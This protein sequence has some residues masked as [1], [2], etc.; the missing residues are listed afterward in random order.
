MNDSLAYTTGVAKGMLRIDP[1]FPID[2]DNS[3]AKTNVFSPYPTSASDPTWWRPLENPRV[4]GISSEYFRDDFIGM[5]SGEEADEMEK[6]IAA[7][8]K[9][10]N[11]GFA[12][13]HQ[14]LFG[15]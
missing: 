9:R 4:P 15:E 5:L 7:F 14:I 2:I 1:T 8:K 11:D 6:K 12:R 13:K 3:S 10:F